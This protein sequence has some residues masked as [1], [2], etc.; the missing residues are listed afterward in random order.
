MGGRQAGS[1][2]P[3]GHEQNGQE[4]L[5]ALYLSLRFQA[6]IL[7]PSTSPVSMA[8]ATRPPPLPASGR[9]EVLVLQRC[10]RCDALRGVVVQ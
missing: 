9:L 4:Q 7:P 10:A 5:P 8:G 1:Q 3:G 2:P 6:A